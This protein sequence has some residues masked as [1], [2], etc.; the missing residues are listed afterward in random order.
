MYSSFWVLPGPLMETRPRAIGRTPP[1][2]NSEI[3]RPL[4]SDVAEGDVGPPHETP[5]TAAPPKQNS[6]RFDVGKSAPFTQD[7]WL[8]VYAWTSTMVTW[9]T[10]SAACATEGRTWSARRRGHVITAHTQGTLWAQQR[11]LCVAVTW[12]RSDKN[13][14]Y[15]KHLERSKCNRGVGGGG[16]RKSSDLVL[17]NEWSGGS[18]E[19]NK[20]TKAIKNVRRTQRKLSQAHLVTYKRPA[21]AGHRC[22]HRPKTGQIVKSPARVEENFA[23][24][25]T[26]GK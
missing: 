7:T 11:R 9:S 18:G 13:R 12:S 24:V 4:H 17:T 10:T 16:G 14:W 1:L 5:P 8:C 22:L 2:S 25:S 20:K 26:P 6:R 19:R 3:A 23:T 15:A 21:H